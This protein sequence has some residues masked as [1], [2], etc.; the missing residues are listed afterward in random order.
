MSIQSDYELAQ[1]GINEDQVVNWYR[2]NG[3]QTY[4][5]IPVSDD[6]EGRYSKDMFEA[7]KVLADWIINKNH[8]VYLHDTTGVSRCATLADV[9]LCLNMK[10]QNW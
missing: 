4:L 6:D 2:R 8:R 3:I 1:R 9:Y 5:R 7:Q 10:S